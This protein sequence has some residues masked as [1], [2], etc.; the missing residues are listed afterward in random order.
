M[1][2]LLFFVLLGLFRNWFFRRLSSLG[3]KP[4]GGRSIKNLSNR[5][6]VLS[7]IGFFVGCPRLEIN[8]VMSPCEVSYKPAGLWV[9][10]S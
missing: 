6:A 2:S 9:G 8:L 7:A 4:P 5:I 1:L 3:D 10:V